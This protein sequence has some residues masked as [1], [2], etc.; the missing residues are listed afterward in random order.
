MATVRDFKRLPKGGGGCAPRKRFSSFFE[1]LVFGEEV[2][3]TCVPPPGVVLAL[4]AV[5]LL[6]PIASA[7]SRSIDMEVGTNADGS[8]YLRPGNVTVTKGDEVTLGIKN[9]DRIFHDVAL[10]DYA[11]EDVEIEAPAGR[12]SSHTFVASVAGDFRLICEVSGHKQKGM[13]GFLHVE[14]P[15]AKRAPGL[16]LVGLLAIGLASAALSSRRR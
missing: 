6:S 15:D 13:F 12:T 3:W 1:R 8:M 7:A 11:G 4:L 16:G 10:L 5:L 2:G 14:D 9:V